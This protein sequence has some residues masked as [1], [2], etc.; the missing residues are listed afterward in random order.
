[1]PRYMHSD[2]TDDLLPDIINLAE[3]I[4]KRNEIERNIN[5]FY[6]FMKFIFI[7]LNNTLVSLQFRFVYWKA[8]RLENCSKSRP[9]LYRKE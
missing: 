1:M 3:Q 4:N 7:S 9:L 8:F 6:K 2:D 5:K